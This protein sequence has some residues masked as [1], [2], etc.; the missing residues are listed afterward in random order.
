MR[1]VVR[2]QGGFAGV[3]AEGVREDSDLSPE[4][5]TAIQSLLNKPPTPSA[6]AP[7]ADRFSYQV[8]VEHDG[9]THNLAIG[10]DAMPA[11]LA[12]IAAIRL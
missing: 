12:Q 4:Q 6:P 11:S 9:A 8:T 7:G 5:R 1:I 3:P 10:E 2:R